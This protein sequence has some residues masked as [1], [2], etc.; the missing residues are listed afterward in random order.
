MRRVIAARLT[1]SKA[2]VPHAYARG[3]ARLGAV[4]R[5]R[6][7]LKAGGVRASV[8]DF[9]VAA[10][11]RALLDVPALNVRWSE[12]EGGAVAAE[13]VDIAIAVAT[14]GG[15]ITPIVTAAPSRSL[16]DVGA[17]VRDLAE[18][19]RANKLAPHEFQGGSF[20]ISNLGMFGVTHFSAIINPPQAAILA[21]GG[22]RPEAVVGEGGGVEFEEVAGVTL[23]YDA[24][25]VEAADAAA[26][27]DAFA[28]HL[29]APERLVEGV[30]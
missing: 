29:E 13:G 23:S 14:E 6:A 15:L 27:L 17:T 22:G 1:E 25:A 26:W 8:N 20:T 3:D 10:A 4:A 21:V 16:T 5:L 18:R 12:A 2:S 19:A 9:V 28:A 7:S 24:R 30:A 11:A